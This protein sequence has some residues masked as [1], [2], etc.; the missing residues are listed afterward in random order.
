MK[1]KDTGN[2][3]PIRKQITFRKPTNHKIGCKRLV[4]GAKVKY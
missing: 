3:E 1:T 4:G 2:I